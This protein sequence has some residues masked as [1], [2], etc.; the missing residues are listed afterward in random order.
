MDAIEVVARN[1]HER[2]ASR[3]G[4]AS[5]WS[6]LSQVERD[7]WVSDTRDALQES[8]VSGW[9][10]VVVAPACNV[11]TSAMKEWGVRA[12][13]SADRTTQPKEDI[14]SSIFGEMLYA[15]PKL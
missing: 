9:I 1:F 7:Q 13:N 12:L 4:Q 2:L 8:Q 10:S 15:R 5:M 14:V 3:T 11:P 6:A